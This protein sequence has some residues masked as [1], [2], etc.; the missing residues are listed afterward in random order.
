MLEHSE[1]LYQAFF[2]WIN[3]IDRS[4]ETWIAAIGNGI[5][6]ETIMAIDR[7]RYEFR[8]RHVRDLFEED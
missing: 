6:C 4:M 3:E 1:N 5:M 8:R 2:D 7:I